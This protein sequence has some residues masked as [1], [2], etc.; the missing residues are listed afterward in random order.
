M[1]DRACH[2]APFVGVAIRWR[3]SST[4]IALADI[5]GASLLIFSMT[6]RKASARSAVAMFDHQPRKPLA[7]DKD[8]TLGQALRK[9][10]CFL[11][12]LARGYKDA[13]RCSHS[14]N[15]YPGTSEPLD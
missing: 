6:G 3:L 2:L 8:D 5:S 11:G 1:T 13:F 7:V 14:H 10:D 9:L 4:A 12:E 15:G